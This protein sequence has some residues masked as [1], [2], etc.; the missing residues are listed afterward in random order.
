LQPGI[1]ITAAHCFNA[2]HTFIK[3][4]FEDGHESDLSLAKLGN[5]LFEESQ[6]FAILKGDTHGVLGIEPE[7]TDGKTPAPCASLGY[8]VEH[9]QKA[10]QCFG[11]LSLRDGRRVFYGRIDFGDSGGPIINKAGHVIGINVQILSDVSKPVFFAVPI[12]NILKALA[13]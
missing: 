3:A 13:K 9:K 7:V 6:D 11:G 5:I 8:G 2:Q 10:S 1:F 12:D 4:T